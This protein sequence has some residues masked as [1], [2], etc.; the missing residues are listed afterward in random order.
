MNVSQENYLSINNILADALRICDDEE[1]RKRNVGWYKRQVKSG[2]DALNFRTFFDIRFEDF[3]MPETLML[4]MPK[5]AWNIIDV[6]AYSGDC[7]KVETSIRIMNKGHFTRDGHNNSYTARNKTGQADNFIVPYWNDVN[8]AYYNIQN[9][10]MIFSDYCSSFD[11]IRLVFNG[12]ASDVDDAAMIPPFIRDALVGYVA[13]RFFFSM[14]A[15]NPAYRVLWMDAKADLYNKKSA[16]ESSPWD[17]A[18]YMLK[19]LDNKQR[20]DLKEYWG[21]LN[22]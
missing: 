11:K 2:L 15:V 20:D 1:M 6:F 12:M 16:R 8:I 22:V 3:D 13:E 4:S 17:E 5:G 9:G 14:K 21:R 10:L 7:Y 19:R 18:Q